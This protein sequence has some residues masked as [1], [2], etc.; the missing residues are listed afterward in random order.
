[1]LLCAARCRPAWRLNCGMFEQRLAKPKLVLADAI[2]Y[3]DQQVCSWH[4]HSD[5]SV[6]LAYAA[7]RTLRPNGRRVLNAR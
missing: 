3:C 5:V 1:M 7:L 4:E 2:A 6:T